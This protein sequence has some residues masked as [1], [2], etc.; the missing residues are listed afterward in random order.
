M[1][2]K[3]LEAERVA[4]L[5]LDPATLIGV[6]YDLAP[7][8]HLLGAAGFC[9]VLAL[10]WNSPASAVLAAGLAGVALIASAARTLDRRVSFPMRQAKHCG[11]G[12]QGIA[13]GF[14]EPECGVVIP[15][16]H[17]RE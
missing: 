2:A 4:G 13:A 17:C 11:P 10:A 15:G 5:H 3:R 6:Q 9:G 8:E 14:D 16:H 12:I 7:S 1:S